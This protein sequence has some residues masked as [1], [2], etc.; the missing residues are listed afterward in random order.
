MRFQPMRSSF[1][2]TGLVIGLCSGLIGCDGAPTTENA[3]ANPGA[4]AGQAKPTAKIPKGKAP[5]SATKGPQPNRK[6]DQ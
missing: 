3:A 5:L 2:I 1:V 6:G 4:D